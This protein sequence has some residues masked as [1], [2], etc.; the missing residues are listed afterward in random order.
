MK[1]PPYK[2]IFA[3]LLAVP[4]SSAQAQILPALSNFDANTGNLKMPS[5]IFDGRL[6]YLEMNVADAGALT[7]QIDEGSVVDITP[8]GSLVGNVS[9][10]LVGTW[11]VDGEDTQFTFNAD[12]T[13]S[14]L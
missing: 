9:T 8:D 14:M 12:G 1:N 13:W 6:Y 7:L 10:N 5:L 2:I 11:N 3:L 4:F